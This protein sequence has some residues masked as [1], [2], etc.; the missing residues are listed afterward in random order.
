M[1]NTFNRFSESVVVCSMSEDRSS[2]SG[3]LR[4]SCW[5][6]QHTKSR[7]SG[8][9]SSRSWLPWSVG[10]SAFASSS[11]DTWWQWC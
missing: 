5:S 3:G 6:V 2:S 9:R 7:R 4:V 11:V 1:M 10:C 8:R